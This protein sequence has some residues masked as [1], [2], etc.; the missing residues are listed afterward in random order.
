MISEK[1]LKELNEQVNYEFESAH[2]YLAMA[3]YCKSQDLDG[4]ANFFVVQAEEER[5]HAMKFYGFIN[6]MGGKVSLRELKSPKNDFESLLE[7]FTD[8]LNH[9]KSVTKRI[10]NLMD[11]ADDERE[12]ATRSMLRWFIDEQVEEEATMAGIIK[13]LERLNENSHGIF[14]L[15]DELG[16]RVFTP[17]TV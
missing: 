3:A 10:Y 15:D 5:F 4:F 14:M 16:Q 8:A 2:I 7:V 1:L 17:P 13:K 12:H 9:E 11:I 6:E